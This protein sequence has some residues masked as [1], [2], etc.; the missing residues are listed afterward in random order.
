MILN[1]SWL[2]HHTRIIGNIKKWVKWVTRT[3]KDFEKQWIKVQTRISNPSLGEISFY[4]STQQIM[5]VFKT[6]NVAILKLPTCCLNALQ[7]WSNFAYSL[8]I[9]LLY[10][11]ILFV[12]NVKWF[13]ANVCARVCVWG[14]GGVCL[15]IM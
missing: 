11:H 2:H 8:L 9:C 12:S 13:Q 14:G 10:R 4:S 7:F 6:R 5:I 1:K 15:Y 3:S